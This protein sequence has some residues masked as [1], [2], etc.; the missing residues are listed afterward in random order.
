MTAFET[1]QQ[2]Y[3]NR[4]DFDL[5]ARDWKEKGGRVIGYPHILCPE[6]IIMA[7]GCLPILMTGDRASGTELAVAAC[8]RVAVA[9][10]E[11]VAMRVAA[12]AVRL[13]NMG[14]RRRWVGKNQ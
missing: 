3:S 5:V 2:Y 11:P 12:K 7:A 8:E 1:F 4:W 14:I 9:M 6:E 10:R 13:G